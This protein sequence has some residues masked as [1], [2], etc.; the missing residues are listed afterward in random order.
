M[1]LYVWTGFSPDYTDGLA[2]AIAEDENHAR[3]IIEDARGFEVYTWGVLEI[4]D[5]DT[6]F[7]ISVCGG[8]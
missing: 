6:P 1:K 2:I 3:K 7:A 4:H 8:A 5:L